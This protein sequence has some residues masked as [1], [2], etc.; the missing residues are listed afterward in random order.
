MTKPKAPEGDLTTFA[1]EDFTHGGVTHSIYRKGSGPAVIVMTEMPGISPMVLGFADRLVALGLTVVLPQLFGTP[2]FD[3]T[4]ASTGARLRTAVKVLSHVC[5]SREFTMFV[6]GRSSPVIDWLRGL[7]VHEHARCGGPGVGAVGMCFTGG[8]ALAM[9]TEP[10]VLVP[11]LSQPSMPVGLTA[12]HR[13]NIDCSAG[14]LAVVAD[15]CARE[16]LRVIGLRFDG[17][18][19]VPPERFAFLR[20]RLGDGFIAVELDQRDGHPE[21]ILKKHHSVLTGGLVDAPGEPTHDALQR[22][23]ELMQ[24]KLLPDRAA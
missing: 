17:D 22:V 16:G 1:C 10:R 8:F 7:A 19:L 5:I 11:V 23:L 9:A 14:E 13:H 3:H 6:A 18:P 21:E 2:G 4:R 12:R 15:R 24:R 20:E